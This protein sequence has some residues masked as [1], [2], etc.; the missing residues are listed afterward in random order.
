[1]AACR[2]KNSDKC[3]S[4]SHLVPRPRNRQASLRLS[5]RPDCPS[6]VCKH[7]VAQ[8]FLISMSTTHLHGRSASKFQILQMQL[9][10]LHMIDRRVQPTA[11]R[12]A[13]VFS[14]LALLQR[15]VESHCTFP[16]PI[17]SFFLHL[18]ASSL[19]FNSPTK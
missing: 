8:L 12:S 18:Q 1:M 13:R 19:C 3:L 6:S 17:S 14:R 11:S 10:N 4:Q 15:R 2:F 7:E 16:Y 5:G 9:S